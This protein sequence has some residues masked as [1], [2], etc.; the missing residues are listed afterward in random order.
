MVMTSVSRPEGAKERVKKLFDV[1]TGCGDHVYENASCPH[2]LNNSAL[3]YRA[4]EPVTTLCVEYAREQVECAGPIETCP[5][6]RHN[7]VHVGCVHATLQ[8]NQAQLQT[9]RG[10]N[11]RLAL[12]LQVSRDARQEWQTRSADALNR[13]LD[14]EAQRDRVTQEKAALEARERALREAVIAANA[15]HYSGDNL[16]WQKTYREL[17]DTLAQSA[18]KR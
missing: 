5:V 3:L 9:L 15:C 14:A 18:P 10:E 17:V 8:A 6:C 12:E 1:L 2:C 11:E 7:T 13:Q 4:L 16:R